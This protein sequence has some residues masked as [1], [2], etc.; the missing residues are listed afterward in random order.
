MAQGWPPD[1]N[2]QEKTPGQWPWV[3][4]TSGAN[5]PGNIQAKDWKFVITD[6]GTTITAT[7]TQAD[8]PTNTLTTSATCTTKFATNYVAITVVNGYLNELTISTDRPQLGFKDDFEAAHDYI[9]EDLG[10]Y[11]GLLDGTIVACN[12]SVNRPG[13]LYLSTVNAIWDP[14]P[15]PMLYVTISGDFVATVKVTEFAGTLAAPVYHNDCG[16]IARD[17]ASDGGQEN[18]V[19]MRYFPTW[20]AFVASSTKDGVRDELGQTTGTWLGSDTFAIAQQYPYIQLER[21]GSNFYFRISSDGV[22]FIPLTD[23]GYQGIFDGTQQPLVISRPDLPTTLQVGLFNCTYSDQIGY[24][25]F[26]DFVITQ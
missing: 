8:D 25:V 26:D 2:I 7:F 13:Q 15:G 1:L 3:S 11:A 6:D 14:G 12:A 16:I 19:S 5:I 22:N 24:A 23:P 20:T 18:W 4:L 17:P 9:L 21:K 10:N